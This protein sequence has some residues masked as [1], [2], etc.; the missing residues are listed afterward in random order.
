M[1]IEAEADIR[2]KEAAE[3]FSRLNQRKVTTADIKN[4]SDWRRDPENARA[5]S[6]LEAM[7]D[8][9]GTL[10]TTPGMAGLTEDAASRARQAPPR[11][12]TSP[13]GRLIPLGAAGAIAV[14]LAV[15]S[16]SWWSAQSPDTYDTAIG[17]QRTVRLDDGSRVVLDTN[18]RITVRFTGARRL[19]TL[20]SGRAMFEVES[21]AARPFLVQ[22]GDTEVTVV[23][24]R[25]DVRRSGSGARVVLVEGRVDVHKPSSTDAQWTLAPGQ[26][27]TTSAPTPRVIAVNVPAETSWT[28]GRLTFEN[29]PIA[30][31]VAEVN[32]YSSKPIELRNER[33]SS[34][35]VSGVF[36]AGDVDGFVAALRDLYHLEAV[37]AADGHVILSE[38]A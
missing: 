38:P 18:S 6:R 9:A 32:R 31:A 35:R 16:W 36:N 23:G 11:R 25:F 17:E 5:F 21:D 4:F 28:V 24:T 20:A 34:I 26:E 10:A 12:R 1:T 15:G 29:T 2:R 37:T 30:A 33:I 19:V 3:W 14:A 8:A 27:V 7:W 13:S 22:A